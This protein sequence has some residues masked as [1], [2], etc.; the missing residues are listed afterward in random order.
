[1]WPVGGGSATLAD[2]RRR[3]EE[4]APDVVLALLE[5]RA[6]L[7]R[8]GLPPGRRRPR[9]RAGRAGRCRCRGAGRSA[10]CGPAR[11]PCCR[12]APSADAIVAA[13]EAAAAGPVVLPADALLDVPQ[14]TAARAA[15]PEA[16]TAR[17]AQILALLAEGLVQQADRR[18]ARHLATHRQDPPGRAVPQARRHHPRRGGGGGGEG[19]SDPAVEDLA[20]ARGQA[21]GGNGCPKPRTYPLG[22]RTANSFIP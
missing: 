17:E 19:G 21:P 3:L 9:A 11:A 14:G 2:A 22:S 13:V 7:P 20:G 10:P 4:T 1:M 12:A 8:L 6:D 15:A 5:R 18:A 16:L